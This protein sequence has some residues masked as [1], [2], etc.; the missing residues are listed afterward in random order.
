MSRPG[1]RRTGRFCRRDAAWICDN[2]RL[3][4]LWRHALIGELRPPPGASD[5]R[6]GRSAK[7]VI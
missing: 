2:E 5:P 4:G 7:K 3:H 1:N 6:K